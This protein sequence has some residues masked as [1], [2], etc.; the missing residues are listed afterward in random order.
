MDIIVS[1][2]NNEEVLVLPIVPPNISISI[3]QDHEDFDSIQGKIKLIG[4][5]GLRT[6]TLESFFPVNKNYSFIRP[7]SE[8]DGWQY[9]NFFEKWRAK[10][11][12]MRIIITSKDDHKRLNM[13]FVVNDFSWAIDRIGDIKYT[14]TIEEYRFVTE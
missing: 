6:L 7:G 14:L 9:V 12:P 3:P 2:N 11:V 10:R 1:A 8:K 4:P 13:P 5:M